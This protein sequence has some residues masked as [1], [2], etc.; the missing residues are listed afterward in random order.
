MT[1]WPVLSP[2]AESLYGWALDR[3]G[4]GDHAEP[5]ADLGASVEDVTRGIS[6]LRQLR[7]LTPAASAP[8]TLV[9]SSPDVAAAE[10]VSPMQVEAM[11]L[12]RRAS[13]LEARLSSLG[14]M[15]LRSRR[16]EPVDVVDGAD[17]VRAVL[18]DI[19]GRCAVEII[20]AHPG[21]VAVD[22]WLVNDLDSRDLGVRALFQH[23]VRVNTGLRAVLGGLVEAGCEIRTCEQI[24]GQVVIVDRETAVIANRPDGAVVIREPSTVDYLSRGL[25]RDWANALPFETEGSSAPRYGPAGDEIKRAIIRLLAAGAKD[26]Q[27]ARRLSI[28][29]RTCRRHI[30]EIMADWEVSSRFQAG[31]KATRVGIA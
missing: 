29:V 8:N 13:D 30:A 31:V 21:I 18:R 23:P 11:E 9:P 16:G 26:E 12:Q 19:V 25:E 7:L 4:I 24:T 2:L 20:S 27:I 22:D 3:G 10:L 28:S 17:R 14:P 15:Y 1:G 5:A 6:A